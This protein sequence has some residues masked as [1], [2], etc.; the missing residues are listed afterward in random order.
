[1]GNEEVRTVIRDT[2]KMFG[3]GG[4]RSVCSGVWVEEGFSAKRERL[5][6]ISML[7]EKSLQINIVNVFL[8]TDPDIFQNIFHIY[9]YYDNFRKKENKKNYLECYHPDLLLNF[10]VFFSGN[11]STSICQGFISFSSLTSTSRTI[12]VSSLPYLY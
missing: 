9:T 10:S 5:D 11:M 6:Y 2:F 8:L 12:S 7:I 1:M 4:D 3:L